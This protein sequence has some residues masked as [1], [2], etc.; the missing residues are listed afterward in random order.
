M[1]E[2]PPPTATGGT[3]P[4]TAAD[5]HLVSHIFNI[6]VFVVGGVALAFLMHSLGLANA[7]R[8]MQDVGPWLGVIVGLDLAAMACDS[9]AIHAF[10]RP[11]ARMVSYWRVLAAQAS[12]RAINVLTP[13]GAL[14]EATKVAMLVGHAP[15]DRIVSAIVEYN[16]VTLYLSV[17]ILVIGVPV[18]AGLV[19]LPHEVALVAWIGLAVIVLLVIALAVV[20]RRGAVATVLAGARLARVVSRERAAA[21][22][23]KLVELDRR[24]R[25]LHA[26]RSPGT[27]RGVA[28]LV[29]SRLCSWA[30]TTAVLSA[31]GAAISPTLLIGV[32][33]VGILIGWVSSIVPLGVGIADGGN[34]ALF[35]VLGASGAHG[36]VVT[37]LGRVR[38]LVVA[39]IGLGV[40]A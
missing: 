36:V 18:T 2:P 35:D 26:N 11:E 37:M 39:L 19:D 3:P 10:M 29:A 4:P 22:T 8:V 12:G 38:S 14:G 5:R 16:L 31:V 40:M 24:L 17:A 23:A 1:S 32:F 15:R 6:V 34:Y 9:G 30:A 21:W 33:S 28:L 13:G 27:G 7:E 20:I 25:E